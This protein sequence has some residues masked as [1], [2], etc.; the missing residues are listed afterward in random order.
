MLRGITSKQN[1]DFDCLNCFY[2]FT[3]ENALEKH[4]NVCK[5]HDYCYVEMSDKGNN[6]LKHNPGEEFMKVPFVNIK[7]VT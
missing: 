5:N 3:T 1:G 4:E 6:I 2:S 7:K